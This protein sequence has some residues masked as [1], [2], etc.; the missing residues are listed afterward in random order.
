MSKNTYSLEEAAERLGITKEEVRQQIDSML[1]Y[2]GALLEDYERARDTEVLQ[3][4]L[5]RRWKKRTRKPK[6]RVR[7]KKSKWVK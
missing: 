5:R 6:I 1:F 7:R 3:Q 2:P 4:W